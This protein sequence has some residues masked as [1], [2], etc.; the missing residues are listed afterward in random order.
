MPLAI[1]P[2]TTLL[3]PKPGQPIPH[4][5]VVLTKPDGAPLQI[6]IVNLT[7]KRETSDLTVV[8]DRGDHPFIKHP[9]VVNYSD[10]RFVEVSLL[11]QAVNRRYFRQHSPFTPAVLKKIQQGLLKSP[12]TPLKIKHY[13]KSKFQEF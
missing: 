1:Q 7:T 2:G 10:A 3:L 8:L 12:F 13:C 9:T 6:I 4:L 5:W 11:E